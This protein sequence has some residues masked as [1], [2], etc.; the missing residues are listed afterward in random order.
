MATL[1][2]RLSGPLSD[3]RRRRRRVKILVVDG[4]GVVLPHPAPIVVGGRGTDAVCMTDA[5]DR[6]REE[7]AVDAVSDTP[8]TDVAAGSVTPERNGKALRE[9]AMSTICNRTIK[10]ISNI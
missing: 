8:A 7:G 5:V 1:T 2:A 3:P 6:G 4:E 9:K 10:R